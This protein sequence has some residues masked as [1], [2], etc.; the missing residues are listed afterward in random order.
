MIYKY[1]KNL[2]ESIEEEQTIEKQ[3]KSASDLN[4]NP[5]LLDKL[6]DH[7]DPSVYSLVAGNASASPNT[8]L[9]LHAKTKNNPNVYLTPEQRK[10]KNATSEIIH[11]NLISNPNTPPHLLKD[12]L[13]KGRKEVLDNPA[14]PL[15]QLED[16]SLTQLFGDTGEAEMFAGQ[17]EDP[18]LLHLL[19]HHPS[20]EVKYAVA[21]NEHITPKTFEKLLND[22]DPLVKYAIA[23][24]DNTPPDVIEKL[25]HEEDPEILREIAGRYDLPRKTFERLAVHNNSAVRQAVIHNKKI[26]DDILHN[27][28]NDPDSSVVDSLSYIE[29]VH[30]EVLHQLAMKHLKN[31]Y[32]SPENT[33]N[34]R[35]NIDWLTNNPNISDETLG[36]IS[37][38]MSLT[39]VSPDDQNRPLELGARAKRL[40]NRRLKNK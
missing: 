30:P 31:I 27:F 2:L 34:S 9:K 10:N 29:K 38:L 17:T 15:L 35:H 1:M 21:R 13:F 26:P 14:I 36:E 40:L 12:Y 6:A 25:S 28:I 11:K 19:A 37:K 5:D 23:G 32:N 24:H 33:Y 7:H 22:P 8:L 39:N 16:P 20:S 18:E 4:T 3:Q